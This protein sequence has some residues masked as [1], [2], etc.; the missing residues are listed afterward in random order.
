MYI[1]FLNEI[2]IISNDISDTELAL[3]HILKTIKATLK[4]GYP[5]LIKF[6]DA[7]ID[8]TK[9][10]SKHYVA[11]TEFVFINI[12]LKNRFPVERNF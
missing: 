11:N 9:L 7:N 1:H 5:V 2:A 8:S 10:R 4:F 3:A 6:N 12:S